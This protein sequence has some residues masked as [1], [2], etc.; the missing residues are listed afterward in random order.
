MNAQKVV[1]DM[2]GRAKADKY[3]ANNKIPSAYYGYFVTQEVQF[4]LGNG[5]SFVKPETKAKLGKSF[6]SIIQ[7]AATNAINAG[8]CFLFWNLDHVEVFPVY[9]G[10]GASFAPLYDEETG[11][12]RAGV[13]FW[14]IA[15]NKPL[16]ATLY[17]PDGYTEYIKRGSEQMTVYNPKRPYIQIVQKSEVSTEIVDGKNYEGFPIIPLYNINNQSELIGNQEVIDSYLWFVGDRAD[18][19]LV[20]VKVRNALS[21]GGFV[22]KTTKNGKGQTSLTLTGHVSIQDQDTMPMEFYSEDPPEDEDFVDKTGLRQ[23]IAFV[24]TLTEADYTSG[25]WTTLQSALTA[26]NAVA[27]VDADVD[28]DDVDDADAALKSAIVGLVERP[29]VNSNSSN[30]FSVSVSGYVRPPYCKSTAFGVSHRITGT[31][32]FCPL[33]TATCRQYAVPT[34]WTES[35]FCAPQPIV[36]MCRMFVISIPAAVKSA[37]AT[38]ARAA[39]FSA[40]VR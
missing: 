6:D 27:D 17:E 30:W 11:A 36:L 24:G 1:Y 26:A 40:S 31:T 33:W 25:S 28:Q 16:R 13:R 3:S 39:F 12:L 21:T 22:L 38:D 37:T 2:L 35:G 32:L 29:P 4:L 34:S 5:V 7:K 10:S 20:A 9:G 15:A 19:G 8:V 23:T 14:Q 18:G